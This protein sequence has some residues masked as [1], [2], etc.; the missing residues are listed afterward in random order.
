MP[1]A[2]ASELDRLLS[3]AGSL[4]L[5]RNLKRSENGNK[6]AA[7]GTYAH[8]WKETGEIL[9]NEEGENAAHARRMRSKLKASG[10]EREVW[11]PSN[12][13]HEV[14]L[15]LNVV[16][17]EVKTP[18]AS[19]LERLTGQAKVAYIN[20]WKEAWGDDWI[21]GTADYISELM[22]LPW[23]D[24]F[25]TGRSGHPKDYEQQQSLYCL[26]WGLLKY[27]DIVPT[28]S[29]ITHWPVYPRNGKPRRTGGLI[30][31]PYFRLFLDRLRDLR[32]RVLHARGGGSL[33]LF[34]GDQCQFCPSSPDCP[35][36]K[37]E[38][39]YVVR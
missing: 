16:T 2:R 27:G 10:T 22:D 23:V 21:T 36:L 28:R 1:L 5:P 34:A 25:K 7:W 3:C 20:A 39:D 8:R 17:L 18:P 33:R 6:A 12:G 29:T 15:A 30:E 31:V 19:Q 9:D 24:D 4:I 35:K 37:G 26:A 13:K 11:W 38:S 14:T 32:Q